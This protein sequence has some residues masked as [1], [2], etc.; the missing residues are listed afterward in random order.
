MNINN[1]V[2]NTF[3]RTYTNTLRCYAT[4]EPAKREQRPQ[5]ELPPIPMRLPEIDE[6]I[7]RVRRPY[8]AKMYM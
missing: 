3:T 1:L 6:E 5:A 8:E 7:G 2:A 4:P